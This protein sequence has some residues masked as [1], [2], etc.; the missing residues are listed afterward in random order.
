MLCPFELEDLFL[1]LPVPPPSSSS[2]EPSKQELIWD[3]E[4]HSMAVIV[5]CMSS[6]SAQFEGLKTDPFFIPWRML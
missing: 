5:V 4:A 2:R 1:L 3:S 6:L